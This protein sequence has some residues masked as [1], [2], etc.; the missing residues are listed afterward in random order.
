VLPKKKIQRLLA[1][2]SSEDKELMLSELLDAIEI[3]RQHNNLLAIE[4][5]LA[6]WDATVELTQLPGLK[7]KVWERYNRLK[8]SGAIRNGTMDN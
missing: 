4:E 6:S 7:D 5:C 3:S 2:L 8:R 1:H